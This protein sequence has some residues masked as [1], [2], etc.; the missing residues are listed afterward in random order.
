MTE[1]AYYPTRIILPQRKIMP[2]KGL[3]N[4][5]YISQKEDYVTQCR[6]IETSPIVV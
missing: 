6:D 3:P 4:F 5:V 2:R 1:L